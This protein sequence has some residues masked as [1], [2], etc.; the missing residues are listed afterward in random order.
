MLLNV[1]LFSLIVLSTLLLAQGANRQKLL[2]WICVGFAVSVFAA[3]L[4]II[5]RRKL[6]AYLSTLIFL[7]SHAIVITKTQSLC[8]EAGHQNKK[9]RVH[10]FLSIILPHVECSRV[11]LLW[12]TY[13]RHLRCGNLTYTSTTNHIYLILIFFFLIYSY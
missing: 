11:V 8:T 3:P 10:A 4:S 13:Q 9:R 5:V 2:G 6:M 1:G 12:S 7:N